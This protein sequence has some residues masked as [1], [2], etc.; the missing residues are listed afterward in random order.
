ML[1]NAS[2]NCVWNSAGKNILLIAKGMSSAGEASSV[3]H[4]FMPCWVMHVMIVH[5]WDC[6]GRNILLFPKGTKG[7]EEALSI[8]LNVPGY[9]ELP[10]DWAWKQS[11]KLTV[12]DQLTPAKSIVKGGPGLPGGMVC[13]SC[14]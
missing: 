1:G 10:S 5:V 4:G 7:E 13:T 14:S 8:F 11:F 2:G 6:A 3:F 9:K 12:I